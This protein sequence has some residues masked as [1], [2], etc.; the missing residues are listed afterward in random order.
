MA[1]NVD[2]ATVLTGDFGTYHAPDYWSA[3]HG[4]GRLRGQ[5]ADRNTLKPRNILNEHRDPRAAL[6]PRGQG[7]GAPC[8]RIASGGLDRVNSLDVHEHNIL[9]NLRLF[10]GHRRFSS[11]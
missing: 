7:G 1:R 8:F 3:H 9:V 4:C 10:D 6:R 11:R 5:R 2:Q